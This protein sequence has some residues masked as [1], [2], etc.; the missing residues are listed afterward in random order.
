MGHAGGTAGAAEP[1]DWDP[2]DNR[3]RNHAGS[4]LNIVFVFKE[5]G[6]EEDDSVFVNND[7]TVVSVYRWLQSR[8]NDR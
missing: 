8:R 3:K 4:L 1:G 2:A 6:N 5:D 7:G